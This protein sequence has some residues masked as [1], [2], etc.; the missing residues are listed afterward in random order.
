VLVVDDNA[1][2]AHTLALLLQAEG[3]RV[4]VETA[5]AQALA[6]AAA[7]PPDVCL[8]DI[9]LPGLDGFQL[10]R[11]LRALPDMA[12]SRLVAIT[13]YGRDSDRDQAR[14]AGFDH[15]LVKPVDFGQL[16][17]LLRG[18]VHG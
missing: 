14:E 15:H 3:Y 12:A 11:R 5:P 10:A 16:L 17:G 18:T 1:D 8:L 4:A 2:A 9:G 13:G 7:E 6:R